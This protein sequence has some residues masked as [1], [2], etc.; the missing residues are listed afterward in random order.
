[1]NELMLDQWLEAEV[2][3]ERASYR[4]KARKGGIKPLDCVVFRAYDHDPDHYEVVF[5]RTTG[6]MD[7]AGEPKCTVTCL[8]VRREDSRVWQLE[9]L[10]D[11]M[12]FSMVSFWAVLPCKYYHAPKAQ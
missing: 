4:T 2:D 5:H 9:W 12:G 6:K 3:K 1:M 11:S 8:K 7:K 10:L